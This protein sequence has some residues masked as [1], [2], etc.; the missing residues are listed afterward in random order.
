MLDKWV[1]SVSV[2]DTATRGARKADYQA[3]SVTCVPLGETNIP[4]EDAKFVNQVSLSTFRTSPHH[5][6]IRILNNDLFEHPFYPCPSHFL[7]H[8]YWKQ[9]I[10]DDYGHN[11]MIDGLPAA[12]M[13]RDLQTG[14]LFYDIGGFAM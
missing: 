5:Q 1:V 14:E 7:R 13:K 12:E 11:W 8:R 6:G 9:L 3:N 10:K 4:G 2:L